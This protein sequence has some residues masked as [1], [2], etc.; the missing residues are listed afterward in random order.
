M[1]NISTVKSAQAALLPLPEND[2]QLIRRADLPS[3]IGIA[4]QTLCRW[5]TEQRGPK[6]V[7]LGPRLVAYRAG[8]VRAWIRLG[9]IER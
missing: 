1:G 8:D 4:E 2:D 6:F 9:L 3:F 5:A 7:K